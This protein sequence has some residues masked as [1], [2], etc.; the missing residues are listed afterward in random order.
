M[1]KRKLLFI[2]FFLL[3]SQGFPKETEIES[4]RKGKIIS[5][6]ENIEG[7]GFKRALTQGVID[8]PID[9]VWKV[10]TDYNHYKDFM[11]K[12]KE[13]RITEQEG[14]RIRYYSKL[15]MP[16]PIADVSSVCEVI[17]SKDHRSLTFSIVP[18]TGKGVKRF[19]GTWELEPFEGNAERTL[20]KYTLSFEPDRWYPKWAIHLGMKSTIGK[21]MEAIRKRV[22]EVKS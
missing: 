21:I 6:L 19:E 1:K 5:N 2:I 16:W 22:K 4:L 8:A 13:S 11:P 9:K 10:I 17:L 18:G 15:N 7:S 12:G 20:G 3:T 14:N